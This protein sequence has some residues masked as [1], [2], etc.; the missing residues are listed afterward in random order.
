LQWVN[1]D[2]VDVRPILDAAHELLARHHSYRWYGYDDLCEALT[3]D[4]FR[5]WE[6]VGASFALPRFPVTE[7]RTGIY[8]ILE[9]PDTPKKR[10]LQMLEGL[11][12]G[13]TRSFWN[14]D[15]RQVAFHIAGRDMLREAVQEIGQA[16]QLLGDDPSPPQ[17]GP[18][19]D[20]RFAWKGQVDPMPPRLWS[21]ARV[22]WGRCPIKV[23]AVVEQVWGADGEE[24]VDS[25]VRSRLSELNYFYDRLPGGGAPQYHLRKGKIVEE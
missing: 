5:L 18:T 6:V 4:L 16:V 8:V 11:L 7:R 15:V 2:H 14:V 23:Q 24:P 21:L 20:G 1:V 13:L 10:G 19:E 17:D 25:T 3:P 12:G 22:L 9:G